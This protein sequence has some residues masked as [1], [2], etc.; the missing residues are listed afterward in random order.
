VDVDLLRFPCSILSLDVQDVMGSHSVNVHG[1]LMKYRL[2]KNRNVLGEEVY[3]VKEKEKGKEH[4]NEEDD[5]SMSPDYELVKKQITD[6]EGCRL[7][8]YFY[9]NKVPGNFHI[10]S[11]AFGPTVQR[12]YSDGYFNFDLSHKINH[13]SFGDD[14]DLKIIKKTFKTGELNPLDNT[15]KN[16]NS[17]KLYEYYLKV[18]EKIIIIFK[19]YLLVYYKS[20]KLMIFLKKLLI[21]STYCNISKFLLN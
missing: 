6:Q 18:R 9:V 4:S 21:I 19:N 15:E 16:E 7:R 13:I 8:G 20:L 3:Q 14:K 1:S 5:E 17:K 2:D 11:H 10:S 12:L